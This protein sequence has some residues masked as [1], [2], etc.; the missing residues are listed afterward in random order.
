[1]CGWP[2]ACY[3]RENLACRGA[4]ARA[5]GFRPETR[6]AYHDDSVAPILRPTSRRRRIPKNTTCC[7]RAWAGWNRILCDDGSRLIRRSISGGPSRRPRQPNSPRRP[8]HPCPIQPVAHLVESIPK[9]LDDLRG[10]QVCNTPRTVLVRLT[11]CRHVDDRPDGDVLGASRRS[12]QRRRKGGSPPR[13]LT[14]WAP[15]TVRALYE[16][17]RARRQRGVRIRILQSPVFSGQKQES[18]TL[19]AEAPK[20]DLDPFDRHGQVVWWRLASCTRRSGS[21]THAIIYLGS[22]NMDWKAIAR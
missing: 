2:S 4:R 19:Q 21:S 7:T 22:A 8:F 11:G 16:S 18:E 15:T 17:L 6:L 3:V 20:P 5:D 12:R 9:G 10:T 1:M 14:G 13:S